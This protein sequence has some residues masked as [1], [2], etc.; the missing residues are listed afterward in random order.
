MYLLDIHITLYYNCIYNTT[1]S[2]PRPSTKSDTSSTKSLNLQYYHD[3]YYILLYNIHIQ[4][5]NMIVWHYTKGTKIPK[6]IDNISS[7]LIMNLL[8]RYLIKLINF[9]NIGNIIN[10][11]MFFIF[12]YS[13]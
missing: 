11:I 2:H 13:M 5:T 8:I 7:Y 10:H 4:I 3:C 1:I 6:L 9:V 12:T